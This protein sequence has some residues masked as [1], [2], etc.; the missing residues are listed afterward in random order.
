MSL[1]GQ[2]QVF[3]DDDI[4]CDRAYKATMTCIKNDS[5]VYAMFKSDFVRFFKAEGGQKWKTLVELS[6]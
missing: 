4:T 2:G 1:I 6:N 5:F 3:G